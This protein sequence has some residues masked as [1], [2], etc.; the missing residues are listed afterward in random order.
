MGLFN[1]FKKKDK[2]KE[3]NL[4]S[5]AGM[6]D[7]VKDN[8]DNPT[9]E[10]VLKAVKTIAKPDKDQEHMKK[11]GSFPFGW[12]TLNKEFTDKMQTEYSYFLSKWTN[13]RNLSPKE[14][15]SALKSFVLY[16]ENARKLCYSK[17]ECFAFW[18]D[19]VLTG[20]GYVEKRKAELKEL[21]SNFQNLQKEY[22][23]KQ[24]TLYCLD[25][26]VMK[27]LKQNDGILQADFLKMFDPCVKSDVSNLLYMWNNEGKIKR[28]KMGRSYILHI[29]EKK[30]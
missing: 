11:D 4:L 15:Y 26:K 28:T 14:Q 24:E 21:E 23:H 17:G 12:H 1:I 8:L 2:A 30:G 20:T 10:N 5:G 18:F 19:E 6:I 25:K 3:Y 7:Y 16:I 9:N 22:E 13:A 29:N 27:M